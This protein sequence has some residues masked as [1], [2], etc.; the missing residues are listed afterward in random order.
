[1]KAHSKSYEEAYKMIKSKRKV[2][3]PNLGFVYQLKDLEGRKTE[4]SLTTK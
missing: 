4:F 3:M 1:M 2:A